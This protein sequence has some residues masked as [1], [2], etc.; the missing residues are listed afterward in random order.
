MAIVEASVVPIYSPITVPLSIVALLLG[1]AAV[2][3]VIRADPG[4]LPAILRA[5]FRKGPGDDDRGD[6]PPALP[7]T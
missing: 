6:D 4:D 7:G 5:I 3:A 2:V 1:V